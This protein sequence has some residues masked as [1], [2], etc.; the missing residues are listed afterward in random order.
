[1][2]VNRSAKVA[3]SKKQWPV[4]IVSILKG[5]VVLCVYLVKLV[6]V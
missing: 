3:V 1:M 5:R 2:G 4:S 6:H